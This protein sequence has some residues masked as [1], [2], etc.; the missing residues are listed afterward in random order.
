MERWMDPIL[1]AGSPQGSSLG[2]VAAFEWLGRHDQLA[3]VRMPDDMLTDA[4]A[5]LNGRQETPVLIHEDGA[6]TETMAI[7]LWLEARDRERRISFA[8]GTPLADR[9]HQYMAFLNSSFTAAFS[10][11]WAALEV[12]GVSDDYRDALRRFGRGAVAK[13]HQQLEAM[14]GDSPYLLGDRPTLAD[15]LFTGVARWA[16]FHRAIDPADYPR[17]RALKER[18]QA[19]PA[20]RFAH[21]VEDGKRLPATGAA[22]RLVAL[23]QAMGRVM[24]P[25]S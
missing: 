2:L 21:A 6:L 9:L 19:D 15:A 11:L 12:K 4:Y 1:L 7:A 3:R 13:R 20:V 22:A 17:I 25:A 10:P 14:M 23:E 5:R 8:P 16:D 24:A 18:L